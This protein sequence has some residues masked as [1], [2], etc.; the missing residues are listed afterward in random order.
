MRKEPLAFVSVIV[1]VYNGEST[2]VKCVESLLAQDY[3]PGKFEILILDNGSKD[4][5]IKQLQPFIKDNKIKCLSETKI[6]N[7]Y[8]A[9]NTGAKAAKGD[10][11][12][13]TDAD[14][15]A[16][17]NWLSELLKD[18]GDENIGAFIGDILAYEPKTALEKYYAASM[19]LRNKKEK[20]F[21]G[22]RGGNC[23]LRR[24]CFNLLQGFNAHAASGGDS[25]FLKRMILTT[26]YTY[27]LELDA[28]VFHKNPEKLKTV[29]KRY[30]RFGST[31]YLLKGDAFL[32]ARYMPLT[33][34]LT[35]LLQNLAAL[36][37]RGLVLLS[38][39][40]TYRGRPIRDRRLFLMEPV[41]RMI[42]LTGRFLGRAFKN[43]KFR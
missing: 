16:E 19:S 11:F 40:K 18:A 6:L 36:L 41:I 42:E 26:H 25:D 30:L 38:F 34:N 8:G 43:L 31:M 17:K 13:F 1:P 27:K 24:H 39:R 9:R 14:C 23:A 3:P 20:P 4:E 2:I 33:K 29:F 10:L 22:M 35:A 15:F 32:G 5:T 21:P 12:A 37:L 7:A 28:I